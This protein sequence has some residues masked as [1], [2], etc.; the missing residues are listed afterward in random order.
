MSAV[1]LLG[2]HV[3]VLLDE[4]VDE[5]E[6]ADCWLRLRLCLNRHL[7]RVGKDQRWTDELRVVCHLEQDVFGGFSQAMVL[8]AHLGE[9]VVEEDP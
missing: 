8:V 1:L 6:L 4:L 3:Q 2:D 7:G 9:Q 5:R